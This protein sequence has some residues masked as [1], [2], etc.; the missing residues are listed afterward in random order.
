MTRYKSINE[1]DDLKRI[2]IAPLQAIINLNLL[3]IYRLKWWWQQWFA[4]SL[5]SDSIIVTKLI[6]IIH[7]NGPAP[8]MW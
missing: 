3:L 6:N 1:H 4:N 5:L 2:Y 8:T 7:Q